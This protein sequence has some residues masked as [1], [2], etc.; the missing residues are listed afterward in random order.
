MGRNGVGSFGWGRRNME[1]PRQPAVEASEL[2]AGSVL[3]GSLRRK[4]AIQQGPSY[5]GKK[6]RFAFPFTNL[7]SFHGFPPSIFEVQHLAR[8]HPRLLET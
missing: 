1:R 3:V 4:K 6:E 5:F 8:R 7:Q 2:Q